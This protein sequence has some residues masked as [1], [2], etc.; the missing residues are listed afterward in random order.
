MNLMTAFL[1]AIASPAAGPQEDELTPA[2]SME[3]L[4][5][6]KRLM[7]KAEE[8][9]NDAS[10]EQAETHEKDAVEK[11]AELIR[12]A[13]SP[14]GQSADRQ[15][16]GERRDSRSR[17][18]ERSANPVRQTYDPKRVDPPSKFISK[19]DSGSWGHLPPSVQKALRD[20]SREDVPPEFQEVWKR[21]FEAI[22]QSR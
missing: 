13:R 10:P 6:A 17:P 7:K 5:D 16:P 2:Q 14:R 15:N 20:A 12:K 11:L 8:R 4:E 22:R 1:I 19:G 9:L 3:L 18:P 21:Y